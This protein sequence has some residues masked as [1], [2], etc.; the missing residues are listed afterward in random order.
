[1]PVIP[2]VAAS[3]AAALPASQQAINALSERLSGYGINP[4]T[5]GLSYS[6]QVVAGPAGAYTNK[7][8][9]AK[10]PSGISQDFSADLT[11]INP[12]VAAV[13]IMAMLG[14]KIVA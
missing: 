5:L 4:A 11:L 8:I 14:R 10:F 6:E 1:M 9:T 13:E 12:Q 2:P 7:T 3:A